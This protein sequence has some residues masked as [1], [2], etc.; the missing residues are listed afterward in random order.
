MNTLLPIFLI[1]SG[2]FLAQ[3]EASFGSQFMSTL[4]S[5]AGVCGIILGFHLLK[6]LPLLEGIKTE[7]AKMREAYLMGKRADVLRIIASPHVDGLLKEQAASMV[8]DFDAALVN[9]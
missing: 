4:A 8:T 3:A 7:L 1:T 6:I 9:K 5:S 2:A